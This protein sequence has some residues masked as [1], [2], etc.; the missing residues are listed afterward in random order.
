MSLP[1]LEAAWRAQGAPI[2]GSLAPG[3]T[4]QQLDDAPVTLPAELRRWWGWHDGAVDGAWSGSESAVG[5]GPWHLMSLREAL[6]ERADKMAAG[7]GDL[8][9]DPERWEGQWGRDWLPLVLGSTAFMFA[10]LAGAD[11]DGNVPI[12][13]WDQQPD[14]V[15]TVR[16]PSWTA[17]VTGWAEALEA[18]YFTWSAE[19]GE[20]Q[21]DGVHPPGVLKLL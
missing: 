12:H 6:D 21:T 13:V 14:D 4:A 5:V 2:A 17:V 11:A 19:H 1:R 3:L 7:G 15:Y 20:W 10:D 16:F 9:A 18:G 8:P